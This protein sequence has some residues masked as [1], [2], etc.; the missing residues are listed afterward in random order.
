MDSLSDELRNS[1]C[2]DNVESVLSIP[3]KNDWKLALIS[4]V[5]LLTVASYVLNVIAWNKK[6]IQKPHNTIGTTEIAIKRLSRR[7]WTECLFSICLFW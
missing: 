6:I 1:W 3:S 2:N 4:F 5:S 7:V